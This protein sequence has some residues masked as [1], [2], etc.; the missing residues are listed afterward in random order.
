M[1]EIVHLKPGSAPWPTSG[2][3]GFIVQAQR[4]PAEVAGVTIEDIEPDSLLAQMGIERGDTIL[5]LNRK[6]P[7]TTNELLA[8]ISRGDPHWVELEFRRNHATYQLHFF[9]IDDAI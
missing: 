8:L 4:D 1:H 5:R 6:I 3:F 7:N 9:L 2:Q